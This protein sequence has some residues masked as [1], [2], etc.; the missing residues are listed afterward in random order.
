MESFYNQKRETCH[1]TLISKGDLGLVEWLKWYLPS[2]HEAPS[3]NTSTT[4]KKKIVEE[5][6]A[7]KSE[8][9]KT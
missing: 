5:S 6:F 8:R 4:K 1:N 2:K 9:S 7:I 3:S